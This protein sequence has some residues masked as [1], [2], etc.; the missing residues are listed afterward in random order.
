ML[1]YEYKLDGNTKQYQAIE[2]LSA[3]FNSFAT[4]ICVCGWIGSTSRKTTCRPIVL[5]WPVSILLLGVSTPKLVKP[6]L[7]VLGLLG[8]R[9]R[10]V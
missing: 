7:T 1:V 9:E 10:K 2:E 4:N 3:L 8:Y 5:S 6:V